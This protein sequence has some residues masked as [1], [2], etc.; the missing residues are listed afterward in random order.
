[1]TVSSESMTTANANNDYT[2]AS[3]INLNTAAAGPAQNVGEGIAV[4]RTGLGGSEIWGNTIQVI[5][6]TG[7]PSIVA[8]AMIGS[9]INLTASGAD[10]GGVGTS[11]S[12][13]PWGIRGGIDIIGEPAYSG[14][15]A[16]YQ[17]GYR[18]SSGSSPTSGVSFNQFFVGNGPF[19]R[20]GLDLTFSNQ[21]AGANAVWLATGETI[22]LDTAGTGGAANTTISSNGTTVA[23][24]GG[25]SVNGIAV[26]VTPSVAT[27]GTNP[28]VSGTPYQWA[29]PGTL[30][31][32]CP[33]TY[34]PTSTAAATSA[35]DIGSTSTPSSAV[36]TESEPAGITAGMIHTAHAEVPSGWYY[37]LTATN[38]TIG[39][40]VGV[41]H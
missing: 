8:G 14:S 38:A 25:L 32:A 27:L 2:W 41:V 18:V 12:N 34:S 17:M 10:N 30:Q 31:L 35:L 23:I 36:D 40:C 26:G 9:E 15:S 37:E 20:A 11:Y 19:N 3:V 21:N 24:K 29:G 39:T 7:Q 22:G 6:E 33:I 16:Q 1:M 28:P 4:R 5:D 13:N